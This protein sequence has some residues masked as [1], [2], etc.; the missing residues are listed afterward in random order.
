MSELKRREFIGLSAAGLALAGCGKSDGLTE[1]STGKNQILNL[2]DNIVYESG[3]A[4]PEWG[5]SAYITYN[6]KTI[7]FDAGTFPGILEHNA[8]VFGTDLTSVETAVLSHNH[9]DHIGGFDYL[10]KINP[11]FKL[12]LPND[13]S[14]GETSELNAAMDK[15]FTRGYPFRH[16]NTEFVSE[17]KKIATGINLITTTSPIVGTLWGYPPYHKEPRFFGL[18]ELSLALENEDGKVT[19]ISGCSHS[20]IEEIVKETKQHLGKDVSLVIGGFH[21]IPYSSE[22]VTSIAK[23]MKDELGVEKIACSHCT[24]E[25]AVKI[26]QDIYKENYCAAGLGSRLPL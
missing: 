24:G 18:P 6:G 20:K 13:S 11:D 19:L 25:K 16:S 3:D 7:L 1:K 15:K 26:F 5:F 23:M 17:H 21:H 2:Y 22:Y 8:G 12:F 4:I 14:L 9:G 10:L